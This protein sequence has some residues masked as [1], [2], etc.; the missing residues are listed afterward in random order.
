MLS[1]KQ[2]STPTT[3]EQA[4]TMA[5]AYLAGQGFSSTSWQSGSVQL[6]MVMLFAWLYSAL[7]YM[8]AALLNGGYNDTAEGDFLDHLSASRFDNTR[9]GAVAAQHYVVFT[10]SASAGPYP[11]PG[12]GKVVVAD[13]SRTFRLKATT[14]YPLLAIPSGGSVAMLVEAE[15][16]GS[17]GNLPGI[18]TITRMITTMAGVTCSNQVVPGTTTSLVRNGADAETTPHLRAKNSSKWGGLSIEVTRTGVER[19]AFAWLPSNSKVY[20]EDNN[21]AGPGTVDVYASA[22]SAAIAA[23]DL[24]TLQGKLDGRFLGNN[25]SSGARTKRALAIAAPTFE[26]APTGVVFY[27]PGFLLVDVQG[28]VE[29]ALLKLVKDCPLGGYDYSPGPSSVITYSDFVQ[30]VEDVPGVK[31]FAPTY[32][33]G[34]LTIPSHAVVSLPSAWALIYT[35]T[36]TS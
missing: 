6:T 29:A 3:P 34:N 15:V 30:A 28:D 5:I 4:T 8:I 1:F 2:L 26:F 19:L 35:P 11:A 12:D 9:D 21:P 27:S 7:T 16:A 33:T 10:C 17:D 31:S 20:V 22:E 23:G 25:I 14:D 24:T 32:P 13:A 18:G 36:S